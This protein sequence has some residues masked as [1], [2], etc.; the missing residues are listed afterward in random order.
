MI[1]PFGAPTECLDLQV[2]EHVK[3]FDLSTMVPIW[4]F[5][6]GLESL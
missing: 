5:V 1:F 3:Q 6:L 2:M 4:P